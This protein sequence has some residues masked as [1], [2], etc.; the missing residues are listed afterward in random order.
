MIC[1]P[2]TIGGVV[3][4][5]SMDATEEMAVPP[6]FQHGFPMLEYIDTQREQRTGVTRYSQGLDA[7]ALN[8]TAR[9]IQIIQDASQQRQELIARVYAE[10][11]MKRLFGLILKNVSKYQTRP[12]MIRLRGEWVPMDPRAWKN[13]Y[14]MTVAVGLGT[15]NRDQQAAHAMT[16]LNVQKEIILAPGGEAMITPSN[17]YATLEKLITAIG[18]KSTETYFTDPGKNPQPQQQ[19]PQVDPKVVEIQG[20]QQLQAQ[21]DQMDHQYRMLQAQKDGEVSMF[22]AE[23]DARIKA[24]EAERKAEREGWIAEQNADVSLAKA[25]DDIDIKRLS[26]ETDNEFKADM[27]ETQKKIASEKGADK[28]GSVLGS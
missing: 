5:D 9:G 10:M 21:K 25:I 12:R 1:F 7:E 6:M 11:F 3:E 8:K 27:H 20:K 16:V 4:V 24:W 17:I 19:E 14:D 28:A 2:V 13:K 22:K 23:A 18:W 15:G 26:V